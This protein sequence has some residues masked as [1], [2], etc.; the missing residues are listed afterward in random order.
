MESYFYAAP[1]GTDGLYQLVWNAAAD[2]S[3]GVKLALKTTAP[4][5]K[6]NV[7]APLAGLVP[8]QSAGAALSKTPEL[9]AQAGAQGSI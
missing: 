6:A 5:R 9:F 2:D 1:T 7:V 8:T 3:A 4:V